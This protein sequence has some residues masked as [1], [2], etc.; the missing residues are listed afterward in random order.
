MTKHNNYYAEHHPELYKAMV[1]LYHEMTGFPIEEDPE[2]LYWIDEFV[3]DE[4]PNTVLIELTED[5]YENNS[6]KESYK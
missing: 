2:A 5:T 1:E 6:Q 4:D 3:N